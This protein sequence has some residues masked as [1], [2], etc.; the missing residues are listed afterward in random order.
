MRRAGRNRYRVGWPDIGRF[1]TNLHSSVAFENIVNFL[2]FHMTMRRRGPTDG[3]TSLGQGLIANA[4]IAMCQQLADFRAVLRDKRLHAI[5]IL[6]VH[7][8]PFRQMPRN[9]R[10]LTGHGRFFG[11][12]GR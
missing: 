9:Y 3:Q 1:L 6:N 10:G 2:G 8:D 11:L 12:V 4:R 7:Y 5:E